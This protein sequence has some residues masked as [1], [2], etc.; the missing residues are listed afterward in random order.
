MSLTIYL[1][2]VTLYI[3]GGFCLYVCMRRVL[4]RM[5]HKQ[6]TQ[7]IFLAACSA[8]TLGGVGLATFAFFYI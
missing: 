5:I 4:P 1:F 6:M 3:L 2:V 7:M 8:L